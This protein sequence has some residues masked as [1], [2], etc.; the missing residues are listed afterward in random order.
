ME[1]I[2]LAIHPVGESSSVAAL[3]VGGDVF[4]FVFVL[5]FGLALDFEILESRFVRGGKF[6]G[7][8]VDHRVLLVQIECL[9]L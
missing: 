9:C 4:L 1:N 2:I 5:L 3:L 8:G 6:H 7:V